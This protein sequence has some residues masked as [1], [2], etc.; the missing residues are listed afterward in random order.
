V[1]DVA[2]EETSPGA[3]LDVLVDEALR[4]TRKA[5]KHRN[6]LKGDNFYGNKLAKLRADATN[7]FA[8]LADATAGDTSALAELI[9]AVFSAATSAPDRLDAARELSY[10]LRTSRKQRKTKAASP[11]NELFPLALITKANRGYLVTIANQMNGS[12][13]EGWY[14]CCAV[15]MRRLVEIVLIE[16]FEHQG[17]AHKIKN[18]RDDYIHLSELIDR[19]L[20]EPK[21]R[22][23]RNAKKEL[24]KL[25]NLGHR[26]AHGRHF[27]AQAS[28]IQKVEDGVRVVV[29]EF[30]HHAGLL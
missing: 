24:P 21:L 2:E 28:D 15:M 29:E 6:N 20:A 23:S 26:S 1:A 9:E 22:L 11:G 16:A 25:R 30:L 8:D 10:T 18:A 17:I 19:A 7:A 5:R 12:F 13:S 27:T 14:D 4:L 3:A